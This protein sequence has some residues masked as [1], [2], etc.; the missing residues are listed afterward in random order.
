GYGATDTVLGHFWWQIVELQWNVETK[1]RLVRKCCAGCD[2]QTR[3]QYPLAHGVALLLTPRLTGAG[4]RQWAGANGDRRLIA[5]I[6]TG[7]TAGSR[8][9]QRRRID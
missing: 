8:H 6:A 3:T 2:D 4:Y 9:C 7:Q 5:G 1:V